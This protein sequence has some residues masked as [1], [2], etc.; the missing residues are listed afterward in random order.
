MLKHFLCLTALA[1]TLFTAPAH[2]QLSVRVPIQG[3][4]VTGGSSAGGSAGNPSSGSGTP[5]PAQLSVSGTGAFSAVPVGATSLPL[6]LSVTNAGGAATTVSSA[7]VTAGASDF[8]ANNSCGQ[9]APGATCTVSVVFSPS[10]AGIR[11]GTLTVVSD[12][13]N[14]PQTV[15]LSG[16]GL[17]ALVSASPGIVTFSG[18]MVGATSATQGIT[19]TNSGNAPAPVTLATTSGPFSVKSTT[20]G[21][22]LAA[23]TSCTYNVVFSPTSEG[24]VTGGLNVSTGAG[25]QAIVLSGTGL[26]A[27]GSLSAGSLSFGNLAVGALS[28]PQAVTVTNTGNTALGITS[29][30]VSGQFN[31]AQS[32]GASLPAN[33]SCTVNVGFAPTSMGP[34]NGMLTVTSAAGTYTAALSGTGQQALMSIAPAAVAFGNQI[35][36]TSSAPQTVT[37][38]NAGNIPASVSTPSVSA[39]FSLDSTTCATSLAA[40]SSCTVSV[41]FSP[42]TSG[43]A[44]GTLSVATSAGVQSV[45]L[46]G[47]GQQLSGS[48]SPSS[49]T[50]GSQALNTQ[51]AAQLITV[52][53]TG[54]LALG[55]NSIITTG[56]FTSTSTCG[57]SVAVGSS[58]TVSVAF[59]PTSAGSQSGSLAVNTA[60]GTYT[61]PLS[62][63]GSLG[64]TALLMHMDSLPFTDVVGNAVTNFGSTQLSTGIAAFSN[65]AKFS[66]GQALALPSSA[67]DF[68]AKDHTVE[69]WVYPTVNDGSYRT[70]V[71][72]SW[73][74]QLYAVNGSLSLYVSA[75]ATGGS[76]FVSLSTAAG[77]LPAN[78]WSDVAV[79]RQGSVWTIYVNGVA[80]ASTTANGT[81]ATPVYPASIGAIYVSNTV[82]EYFFQGYID[83]VKVTKGAATHTGNYAPAT[84]PSAN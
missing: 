31:A 82:N 62:G 51:S 57:T 22:S 44:P 43:S 27:S 21:A 78:A 84:G 5:T 3:L 35:A 16:T 67:L 13:S 70:L 66:G 58:C 41:V 46:T 26:V 37:L 75:S 42:V 32:C 83:E 61:V 79:T 34:Q 68:G 19:L 7:S 53:N 69:L 39:G 18:E 40:G 71:S 4:T 10:A 9:L 15:N 2:A 54:N 76:Y 36:G 81:M 45:A 74:W 23:G 30:S 38:T 63:T 48:A 77:V 1:A 17:K 80:K 49:L 12:A 52:A 25:N 11:G 59:A 47:T 55:I 33:G 72:G 65:S 14:S 56:Q 20:C 64:S 6:V 24:A 73:G 28:A 50:F 60:G 8:S 29:I